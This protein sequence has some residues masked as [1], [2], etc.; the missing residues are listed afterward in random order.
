M[1]CPDLCQSADSGTPRLICFGIRFVGASPHG[2]PSSGSCALACRSKGFRETLHML[3]PTGEPPVLSCRLTPRCAALL[4][5]R[6]TSRSSLISDLTATASS[7]LGRSGVNFVRER[8]AGLEIRD[9]CKRRVL[10]GAKGLT[11]EERLVPGHDHVRKR[12]EALDH[13]VLDHSVRQIPE[14]ETGLFF[15]NVDRQAAEL[16]GFERLDCRLCVDQ[17]ATARVDQ[18]RAFL[19]TVERAGVDDMMGLRRQWT[20][21]RDDIRL[22]L[23]LLCRDVVAADLFEFGR[24][25]RV[26]SDQLAAK[27]GHDP[28]KDGADPSGADDSHGA[29]H[30]I[31]AHEAVEVEIALASAVVGA[32]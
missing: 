6:K 3:S 15:V 19:D 12:H 14:E 20:M 5:N 22:G 29:A 26:E 30:E 25:V 2:R 9:A 28:G 32:R 8:A 31:K 24:M 4:F 16:A 7:R 1:M 13:V 11:R 18:E 10:D 23:N 27:S 17:S 21:R